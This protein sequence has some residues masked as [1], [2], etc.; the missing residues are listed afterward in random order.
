MPDIN[1]SAPPDTSSKIASKISASS[2]LQADSWHKL[3]CLVEG[4]A[5]TKSSA[6]AT[7]SSAHN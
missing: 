4:L 3:I 1:G 6:A 2:S 7:S 5:T